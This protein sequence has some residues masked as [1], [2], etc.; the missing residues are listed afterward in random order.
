[1]GE[2][3]EGSAQVVRR[4][5]DADPVT[6]SGDRLEDPLGPERTALDLG[7]GRHRDGADVAV[8]A[9]EVDDRPAA[10]SLSDRVEAQA[11][12]LPAPQQQAQQDAVAQAF[13]RCRVGAAS[14]C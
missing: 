6:V 2:L 5:P 3:G 8:L 1:M 11:C 14:S 9:D 10:F 13:R 12:E 4:D 7:S